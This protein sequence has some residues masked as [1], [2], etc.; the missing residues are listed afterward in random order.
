[1]L[2]QE[3]LE[4][5]SETIH[6]GTIRDFSQFG[7]LYYNP[8]KGKEKDE[9]VYIDGGP[10]AKILAVGHTDWVKGY[11]QWATQVTPSIS[12]DGRFVRARQLD[13]RLGV[14][15][16]MHVLPSLLGGL[17]PY[18]ILL[19][20]QEE[21]GNST[22]YFFK[23]PEG[24][25]YNWMFEFDRRGTDVVMYQYETPALLKLLK[26][27]GFEVGNGSFTDICKLDHLGCAGFNFACGYHQEHSENC[28]VDLQDT[29]DQINRFVP[30]YRA[31]HKVKFKKSPNKSRRGNYFDNGDDQYSHH[32]RGWSGY[33]Y[34]WKGDGVS[35]G[36][37]NDDDTV[38]F[39]DDDVLTIGLSP[40]VANLW[41]EWYNS[42]SQDTW[43]AYL[44]K[45]GFLMK[46]GVILEGGVGLTDANDT[47]PPLSQS[48]R[49]GD[50]GMDLTDEEI[51][52][53][54]RYRGPVGKSLKEV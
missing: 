7:D 26:K 49:I 9:Y 25:K 4:R 38:P 42:K 50:D 37:G 5:L 43:E 13:D 32:V 31:Y 30:F 20:D 21:S 44:E 16:I 45:N 1:M 24:K 35:S 12:L 3:L 15:I 17:P 27:S 46:D 41:R 47:F 11:G 40:R 54:M 33:G 48:S 2:S 29:M 6:L 22:A 36:G 52:E 53:L 39:E 8:S 19:T 51:E 18:D 28:H 14:W 34:Q 10:D 23:P